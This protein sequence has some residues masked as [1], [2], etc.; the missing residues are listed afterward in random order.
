MSA[1]SHDASTR[2]P[3][4]TQKELKDR[5]RPNNLHAL[6]LLR[7]AHRVAERARPFAP[8]VLHEHPHNLEPVFPRDAA[9]LF[10]H[11][12][13]IASEMAAHN[14]EDALWVLQC[15]IAQWSPM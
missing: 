15:R 9:N 8:G 10:D 11:F 3:N 7:P 1:Q 13:C 12:W 6:G 2:S 4:I 14:L 5:R